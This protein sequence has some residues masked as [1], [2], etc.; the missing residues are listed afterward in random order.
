MS[1]EM[2]NLYVTDASPNG[3][4][5]C[6]ASITREDWLAL[7]EFAEETEEHV[8]VD[9]KG[10]DP[11]SNMHDGRGA[12]APLVLRLNWATLFSYRSSGGKHINLLELESLIS[13]LGRVTRE[14]I[15]AR[16]LLVLVDTHVVLGAF[17]KGRSS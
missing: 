9:W 10:E 12:T 5:G 8:R 7:Y 4:G 2:S 17:S 11:Q 16:R 14:G 1:C 6:F 3:A 15:R 13:L